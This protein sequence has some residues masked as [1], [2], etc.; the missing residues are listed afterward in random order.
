MTGELVPS[1]LTSPNLDILPVPRTLLL[2]A[3][4][5]SSPEQPRKLAEPQIVD[6]EKKV[7]I[8]SSV[9]ASRNPWTKKKKKET[10]GQRSLVSYS[11]WGC[12][13]SDKTE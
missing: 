3:W 13:D 5:I 6:V 9:L 10:H 1:S 12:K 8:N 11:P 4:G 2:A 7:A